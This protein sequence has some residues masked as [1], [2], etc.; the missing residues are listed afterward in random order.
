MSVLSSLTSCLFFKSKFFLCFFAPSWWLCLFLSSLSPFILQ[1]AECRR[2]AQCQIHLR[3]WKPSLGPPH[4]PCH[5]HPQ[6]S[7][8][9]PIAT[10]HLPR[11]PV[12]QVRSLFLTIVVSTLLQ[13]SH[14][15][16]LNLCFQLPRWP[17]VI[18]LGAVRYTACC[19]RHEDP[20]GLSH[21]TVRM[22]TRQMW[23]RKNCRTSKP[24]VDQQPYFFTSRSALEKPAVVAWAG[25]Y[26]TIYLWLFLKYA[27]LQRWHG[28]VSPDSLL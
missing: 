15:Q 9:Q 26:F 27:Y 25:V 14:F 10:L 21:M 1:V 17:T 5:L 20:S 3:M 13:L 8:K 4:P 22:F 28:N 11:P 23:G 7:A 2:L 16:L 12:N 6:L 18:E 19:L 24:S